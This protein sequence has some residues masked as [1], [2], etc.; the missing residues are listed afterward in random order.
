MQI[1]YTLQHDLLYIQFDDRKQPVRNERLT[2]DI[3]LD[4]GEEDCIV[5][6]EILDASKHIRLES[7]LPVH[8]TALN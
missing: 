4:I 1:T 3:V 7:V 2:D 6:M 5:G 8:F